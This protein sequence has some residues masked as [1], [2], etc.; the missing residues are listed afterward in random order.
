[1]PLG[2]CVIGKSSDQEVIGDYVSRGHSD[3]KADF[4]DRRLCLQEAV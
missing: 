2:D 1:M 3:A 4:I